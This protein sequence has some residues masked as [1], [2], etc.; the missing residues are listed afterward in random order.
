M[1]KFSVKKPFTVLVGIVLAI[2]LGV[3][4]MTQMQL[5]LLPN[6][7][8]PYILVV[9]TYPGASSEKIEAEICQPMEAALGTVNG[10]KNISSSC[11]ENYGMVQLEFE[12]DTDIDSA[13]V[14]VSGAVNT[15]KSS[16][17]EDAGTPSIIELSMDMV[18]SVYLGISVEGKEIEELSQMVKD[19]I[20]PYYERQNGVASVTTMGLVDKIIQVELDQAKVD[21]L[22]DKILGTVDGAFE[23]AVKQ[24]NNARDKL[25][26]SGENL[27]KNKDKLIEN[28]EKLDENEGKLIE[29]WSDLTDQEE[30]IGTG[31]AALEKKIQELQANKAALDA[32]KA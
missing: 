10:V 23:K 25:V 19:D 32:A 22:N 18:A 13:M 14:K 24:L 28:Q 15:L 16:L 5:D 6:I 2:V 29:S 1:S 17:P 11:N 30:A 27:E 26:E 12:D 9:T 4:S 31:V 7:S 8:L 3:V 21:A 20:T